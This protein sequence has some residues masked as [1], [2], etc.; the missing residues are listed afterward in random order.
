MYLLAFFPL[1]LIFH[2]LYQFA[3]SIYRGIVICFSL[4]VILRNLQ[5]FI[6]FLY[7]TFCYKINTIVE[8]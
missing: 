3:S 1:T 4:E 7:L 2:N 5:V 8:L 6:V